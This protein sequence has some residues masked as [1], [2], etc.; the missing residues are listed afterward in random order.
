MT[1]SCYPL[2]NTIDSPADLRRLDAG[3]LPQ[4]AAELR[5]YLINN[6]A[7]NGG[8][9]SAGLG[10]VEITI[11]LH[12]L[13]NTPHDR[14]VWDT[15]HQTYP[16]KVLTGRRDALPK[17]RKKGGISGFPKR[18]DRLCW[19]CPEVWAATRPAKPRR[20]RAFAGQP[21]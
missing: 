6:A 10:T 12:Y 9:F 3:Q 16:H 7:A 19:F 14:I 17:I 5:D 13:L 11:A 8:H 18:S 1:T 20:W 2:L 15:G 4:L 21:T